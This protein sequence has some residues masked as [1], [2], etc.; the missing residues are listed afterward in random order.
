MRLC[1]VTTTLVLL[2]LIVIGISPEASSYRTEFHERYLHCPYPSGTT[3]FTNEFSV[4]IT[5]ESTLK[6]CKQANSCYLPEILIVSCYSKVTWHNDDS[7]VHLISSGSQDDG[8]DGWFASQMIYPSSEFSYFFERPGIYRFYD[9][10]YSWTQG[11]II[12]TS[13]D[14]NIDS[15]WL[16]FVIGSNCTIGE[17]HCIHP[18]LK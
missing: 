5:K 6:G 10:L 9:P 13:G 12:V 7:N 14:Y 15:E 8:T 16:K 18:S 4:A 1:F 17:P 3:T 2:T 11:T